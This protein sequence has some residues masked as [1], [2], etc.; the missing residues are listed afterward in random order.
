MGKNRNVYNSLSLLKSCTFKQD[1]FV[2]KV[3]RTIKLVKSEL[4]C[5]F[6]LFEGNS[7]SSSP[8]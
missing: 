5:L 4:F 3:K 7:C 1:V 2:L 6:L 8:K